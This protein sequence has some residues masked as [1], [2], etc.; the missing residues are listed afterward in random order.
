[1]N[2]CVPTKQANNGI[3]LMATNILQ[4]P[5]SNPSKRSI[6][7]PVLYIFPNINMVAM[8]DMINPLIAAGTISVITM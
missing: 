8:R 5:P 3:L 1:M 2:R 7:K 6:H 4:C